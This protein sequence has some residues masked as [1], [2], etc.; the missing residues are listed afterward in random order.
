MSKLIS[1]NFGAK[2]YQKKYTTLDGNFDIF[3]ENMFIEFSKMEL[4]WFVELFEFQ[5]TPNNKETPNNNQIFGR[6]G[7]T[8]CWSTP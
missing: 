2:S 5:M 8:V 6:S 4:I 1:V 3:G 7:L